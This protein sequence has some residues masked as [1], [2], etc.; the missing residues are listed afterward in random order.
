M[1][2]EED[3]QSYIIIPPEFT[4][5]VRK[6]IVVFDADGGNHFTHYG[7]IEGMF[8]IFDLSA[9][10]K[11]EHRSYFFCGSPDEDEPKYRVSDMPLRSYRH[12][13]RLIAAVRN[14]EV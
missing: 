11:K 2:P 13:R 9:K 3:I 6:D 8:L 12:T 5:N 14:Y 1:I 7:I 4:N 10:F